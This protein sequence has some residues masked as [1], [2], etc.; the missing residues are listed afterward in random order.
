MGGRFGYVHIDR[1]DS[2]A[3]YLELRVRW[4]LSIKQHRKNRAWR[5]YAKTLPAGTAMTQIFSSDALRITPFVVKAGS[6]FE[7]PEPCACGS[8]RGRLRANQMVECDGCGAMTRSPL[9]VVA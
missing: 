2:H 7:Y 8:L 6:P 1:D 5:A 3:A 4:P 9:R